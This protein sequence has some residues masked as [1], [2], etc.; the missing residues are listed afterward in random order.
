VAPEFRAPTGRTLAPSTTGGFGACPEAGG[1]RFRVA[2]PA[3]RDLQLHLLTG[4]AVG[5]H[6]LTRVGDGVFE[7]H[8]RGAQAGDRY[9]Y[10]LDGS[11]PR[12]DPASRWQPDGVHAPSAIV[13]PAAYRWQHRGWRGRAATELVIYELHIGTFTPEGTFAAARERLGDLADLGITAVELMPVA[14]FPGRRNWGYDGVCLYAPSRAYGHP[15]DLRALV[16]TA[17]G[18]GLAVLLDVVYNH[19]GPEGAYLPQF[20]PQYITDRH[21][22]P[23]GG[24]VNL[25]GPGRDL[26]RRFIID[27]AV[28]WIREY[29]LDGLRLDATH[30]LV[31][32]SRV[33]LVADLTRAL[34]AA[35]DRPVVIHAEDH[36]NLA[37]IVDPPDRG[38]WGADGIWADDFHHVVRRLLAGDR[39]GYY[40]DFAGTTA[41][42]AETI[43]QGWLFTGQHSPHADG[44]RGSDPSDVP[45]HRFVVCLQNHDQIG[46]RAH[47]DRLHHVID[48]AAW[49]A[50]STLLLTVPM[51]PLLFMGQEWAATSPFQY[52]TEMEPDL[53]RLVTEG[54]RREFGAFPAFADPAARER[55]PD[56][57]AESTFERSRLRWDERGS[58]N[59][60]LTLALYRQLLHLRRAHPALAASEAPAGDAV[61]LDAGAML[62]RRQH[63]DERFAIVVQLAGSSTVLIDDAGGG[64][65]SPAL[66]LSTEDERFAP[67]PQPPA[68]ERQDGRLIVRFARPGAIIVRFA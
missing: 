38:G 8:V 53:G 67:D 30:A 1:V 24:A 52:F 23:W 25:D 22:T 35:A 16:D 49:R 44:P 2:A 39:H 47:G 20:N 61:A 13:D 41:E 12:P 19:L 9:V 4:A 43:R 46:N 64:T 59:H 40:S 34:R 63:G 28:H 18:L 6:R 17:H 62:V 14:D 65:S 42:L 26:V 45:M 33:H 32:D 5:V 10:S 51:T 15:D 29:R 66:V 11:E 56:P 36:R 31:D 21:T 68:L 3:T 55:I 50:A 57:Q 27:N 7:G 58:G 37:S 54:R 60:A 48:H